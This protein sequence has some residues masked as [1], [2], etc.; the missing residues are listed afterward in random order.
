MKGVFLLPLKSGRLAR[1]LQEK[2][3]K[4]KKR[5]KKC[6]F[7]TKRIIRLMLLREDVISSRKS[8]GWQTKTVICSNIKIISQND[9]LNNFCE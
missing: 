6:K 2:K 5:E 4:K 8:V 9:E 1:T 3:K 7:I